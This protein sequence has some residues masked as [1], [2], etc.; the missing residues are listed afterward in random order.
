MGKFG[1]I[2]AACF[3]VFIAS[4]LTFTVVFEQGDACEVVLCFGLLRFFRRFSPSEHPV[5]ALPGAPAQFPVLEEHRPLHKYIVWADE[6]VK[7]GEAYIHSLL[8]RPYVGIHLRIGS[9][10][11]WFLREAG[12]YRLVAD[13]LWKKLPEEELCFGGGSPNPAGI[14][15]LAPCSQCRWDSSFK[16]AV[17]LLAEVGHLEVFSHT[18]RSAVVFSL[19]FF[20]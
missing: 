19:F 16:E 3:R 20:Q 13:A 12:C 6:M 5:L 7:K 1:A 8:V 14:Q 18:C 17:T 10:W 15:Q 2:G 9:D 4:I 11:V